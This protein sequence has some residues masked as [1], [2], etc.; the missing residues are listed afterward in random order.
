MKIFDA[1]EASKHIDT[2]RRML[3][4]GK[5]KS[6]I[7]PEMNTFDQDVMKHHQHFQI[8]IDKRH[9]I[10]FMCQD[11][12][13]KKRG[14]G[15]SKEVHGTKDQNMLVDDDNKDEIDA[16]EILC[17]QMRQQSAPEVDIDCFD[18]NPLNYQYFV[19]IFKDVVENRINEPC[20]QLIR[21]IKYTKGEPKELVTNCIHQPPKEGYQI[22]KMLLEKRYGNSHQL[23]R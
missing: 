9:I 5:D 23:L 3:N 19:A 18:G 14:N 4:F 8:P 11:N 13:N 10:D 17:R 16:N 20:G 22:G 12:F 6:V 15:W 21:L 1:E 2:P 7:K